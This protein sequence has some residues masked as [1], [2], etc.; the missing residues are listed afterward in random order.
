MQQRGEEGIEIEV[1]LASGADDTGQDLLRLRSAGRAIPAADLACHDGR[2]N[3]VLGSPIG[4]VDGRIPEKGE[5]RR[6]LHGEMRGQAGRRGQDGRGLDA[7]G[8]AREQSPTRHREPVFG[9]RAGLSPIPQREGIDEHLLHARRP[10]TA[11][12]IGLQRATPTKQMAKH[13]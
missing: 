6:E 9:D 12:M 3:R 10:R 8:Q 5:E 4:G 2:T 7:M 13:V 11:R 1:A